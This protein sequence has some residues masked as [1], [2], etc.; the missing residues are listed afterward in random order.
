MKMPTQYSLIANPDLILTTKITKWWLEDSFHLTYNLLI[1][2]YKRLNTN[3][4]N[5]VINEYKCLINKF[6]VNNQMLSKYIRVAYIN[7]LAVNT[8]PKR[9]QN[10]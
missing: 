7:K 8:H 2:I 1:N 9:R 5:R 4:L 10:R 6:V 3:A